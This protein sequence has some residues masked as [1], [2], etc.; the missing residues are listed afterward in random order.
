MSTAAGKAVDLRQQQLDHARNL[1]G[2]YQAH[3]AAVVP[4]HIK[5][6]AFVELAVA[7]V[8][9][10]RDLLEAAQKNPA[11]LILVLRECAALGHLPLKGTFSLVAFNDKNQPGGKAVVGMEEWRGVV[12]RIYR[13]GGVESVHVETGR[14]NDRVL[15][16]NRTRD[17]LPIHDYDEFA[18]PAERGPLKVVYAWCRMRGG[19]VSQVAWLPR[20][21][22]MRHRAM[23]KT[24]TKAGGNGGAFWGPEE[25]EGPNT[26]AMW[27][28]TALHVLEGLVP[29][30]SAYREHVAVAEAAA[31]GWPEVPDQ[32]VTQAYGANDIDGEVVEG[33]GWPA[34]PAAGS[35][36]LPPKE[37][38]DA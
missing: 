26:E 19:G 25:G 20:Y 10:D 8:K 38:A 22:V 28:K 6:G 1:I 17:Q 3:F 11:S 2:S 13:A 23:S 30:S 27:K 35:G 12:E 37:K 9:R 31:R 4:A 29:T 24:A 36:Q 34:V 18:S 7:Y 16:F 32:S 33:N 15:R 14:E 5:P 21:E